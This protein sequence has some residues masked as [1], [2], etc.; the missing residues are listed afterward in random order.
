[1]EYFADYFEI[2]DHT[3]VNSVAFLYKRPIP[4]EMLRR[5]RI[6]SM[7]R[8]EM[9]ALAMRNLDRF[10]GKQRE[11]LIQSRDHFQQLLANQGWRT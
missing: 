9:D 5:N 7:G 3:E 6:Q 4:A 2:V 1:M 10:T 8:A 11:L